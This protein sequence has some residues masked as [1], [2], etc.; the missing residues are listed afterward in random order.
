MVSFCLLVFAGSL[1]AGTVGTIQLSANPG[2]I[3]ADGRSYCTVNALIE[4]RY[5]N[6]VPN[7]TQ[8]HFS[9]SLG[10]V[11]ESAST[12]GGVA[13]VKLIS[14]SMKGTAVVTATWIEGQAVAQ[15]SVEFGDKTV[16]ATGPR[17]IMVKADRYLAYSLD[18]KVVD[19][20]G[21]V[22]IRYRSLEMEAA[23]AQVDIVERKLVAKGDAMHLVKIH[24]T[25]GDVTGN[26]FF[27]NLGV[28][29]VLLSTSSGQALKI[30]LTKGTPVAVGKTSEFRRRDFDFKDLSDSLGLIKAR[31]A[32]VFLNE[33]IQFTSASLYVDG[34]RRFHLPM[35][36][37]S[38]NGYQVDGRPYLD[39]T[40]N[41]IEVNLPFYY[42]LSPTSDGAFIITHASTPGWGSYGQ[43]PGWGLDVRQQYR[44]D[45][46][47]GVLEFSQ[48][49]TPDWAAHFQ[50]SQQLDPATQIY[51]DADFYSQEDIFGNF[52]VNHSFNQFNLGMNLSGS[53]L[54]EGQGNTLSGD[55]SAQTK[56][57][58]IGKSIFK[59]TAS[60][61]VAYTQGDTNDAEFYGK[62]R[63]AST[64]AVS[65][66]DMTTRV[67]TPSVLGNV[68]TTPYN[69]TKTLSIA[70]SGSLGYLWSD[71]SSLSGMSE[72]ATTGLTWKI[73][74]KMNCM[75][76]YRYA[77]NASVYATDVGTQSLTA[78]WRYDGGRWQGSVFAVEGLDYQSTNVFGNLTVRFG[79][80]WMAGLR[81]TLDDFSGLSYRDLEVSIGRKIGS[82][83]LIVLW[84]KSQHRIMFNLSGAGF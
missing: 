62:H 47:Q 61:T 73:S 51:M 37:L 38:L 48:I 68:Y 15:V 23:E 19:A 1:Q 29:G 17:Y 28:G 64:A 24:T 46:A 66:P 32:A 16:V 12:Q 70:G 83:D 81:A 80:M 13:R 77:A 35:Y 52:S 82:K 7:G 40:T 27:C 30:D 5:G 78:T 72:I 36:V 8:I 33:K 43:T 63:P 21:R 60:G 58:S 26:L 31:T 4:D 76:G 44:T 49:T 84:S 6:L 69:I 41:G 11:D 71:Q 42:S 67:L 18:H 50:H 54:G 65:S 75:M 20:V 79:P 59:W 34:K 9:T 55:V 14:S 45:T 74:P 25:K 10:V 2:A 57:K 22:S 39:L 3:V 56:P 53:K